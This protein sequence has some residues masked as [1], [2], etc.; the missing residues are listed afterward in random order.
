MT[1]RLSGLVALL[2]YSLQRR[3]W[4]IQMSDG[5]SREKVGCILHS[6][7]SG[8]NEAG[9]QTGRHALSCLCD[10][11]RCGLNGRSMTS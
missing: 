10:K 5:A 4:E 7:S 2:A 6:V 9:T 8:V 11:L 1:Y 3:G